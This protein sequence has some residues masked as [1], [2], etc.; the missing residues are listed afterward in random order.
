MPGSFI[1][2]AWPIAARAATV[3]AMRAE[4]EP[5]RIDRHDALR[6]QQLAHGLL[7]MEALERLGQQQDEE[8]LV[9]RVRTL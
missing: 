6:A 3:G 9:H 2:F 4:R 7:E 1:R 5:R 8:R